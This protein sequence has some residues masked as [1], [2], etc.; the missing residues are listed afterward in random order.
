V[1]VVDPGVV[2]GLRVTCDAFVDKS[3]VTA[4]NRAVAKAVAIAVPVVGQGRSVHNHG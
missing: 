3:L 2:E 4:V 1:R